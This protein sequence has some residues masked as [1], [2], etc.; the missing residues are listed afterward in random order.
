MCEPRSKSISKAMGSSFDR[1]IRRFH[2]FSSAVLAEFCRAWP[3]TNEARAARAELLQRKA[4][5]YAEWCGL[6]RRWGDGA[7]R[8]EGDMDQEAGMSG[9]RA[10]CV[11]S[12][13]DLR[14]AFAAHKQGAAKFTRRMAIAIAEMAD[15]RPMSLVWRLEKM[16]LL[17]RGSWEWF[18]NNGGITREHIEEVRADMENG[19]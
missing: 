3:G 15:M 4:L 6:L 5:P 19:I 11:M 13:D 2:T 9:N 16:G 1:P 7:V 8:A 10:P 18:R 17:K 12:D 14:A